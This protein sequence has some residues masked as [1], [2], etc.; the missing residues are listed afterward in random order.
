MKDLTG[1]RFGKLTVVSKGRRPPKSR[2]ARASWDMWWKCMCDC[3]GTITVHWNNLNKARGG[4]TSCGCGRRKHGMSFHP[5]Y[6]S[7]N[8]MLN[9]CR[10]PKTDSYPYYGGKGIRV[11][12]AWHKFSNFRDWALANNWEEGLS[13]DRI[14]TSKHYTPTNCRWATPLQQGEHRRNL[15]YVPYDGEMIPV[16]EA[17]RR[18]G[19]PRTTILERMGRGWPSKDLYIK[20]AWTRKK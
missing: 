9:R 1:K 19:V 7:W 14:D 12:K 18:S 20:T 5:L 16:A 8:A 17:V 15:V 6:R 2:R 13:I 11:C 4:T 10:N 3:G